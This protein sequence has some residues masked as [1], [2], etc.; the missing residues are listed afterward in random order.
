M[1]HYR[2][3]RLTLEISLATP[4]LEIGL[5]AGPGTL[6]VPFQLPEQLSSVQDLSLRQ[7]IPSS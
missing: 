1:A 5:E 2:R 4:S 3:L 7:S 6:N